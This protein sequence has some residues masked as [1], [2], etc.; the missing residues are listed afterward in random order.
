MQ[1][2]VLF[3]L[4]PLAVAAV[5]AVLLLLGLGRGGHAPLKWDSGQK[6]EGSVWKLLL[7]VRGV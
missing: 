1:L 5:A 6:S 4:R 2:F 3:S 7:E